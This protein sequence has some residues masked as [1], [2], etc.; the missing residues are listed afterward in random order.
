[1]SVER[2]Q[3]SPSGLNKLRYGFMR[4]FS[5][6]PT[7]PYSSTQRPCLFAYLLNPGPFAP[8]NGPFVSGMKWSI[9]ASWT[10]FSKRTSKHRRAQL[11]N[12]KTALRCGLNDS[13]NGRQEEKARDRMNF[14]Q[15]P[16]D[17]RF[18]ISLKRML[19][20]KETKEHDGKKKITDSATWLLP[21]TRRS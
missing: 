15:V 18:A 3:T 17:K 6:L 9:S 1:M 7:R 14:Q 19:R 4:P 5:F 16:P 13:M 11:M 21:L 20:R 8:S 2:A 12:R 10:P